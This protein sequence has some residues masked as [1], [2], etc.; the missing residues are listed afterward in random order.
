MEKRC[1]VWGRRIENQCL[2]SRLTCVF[3]WVASM[4][5]ED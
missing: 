1:F 4:D 5:F 2:T 3:T